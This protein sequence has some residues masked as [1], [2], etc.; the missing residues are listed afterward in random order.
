MHWPTVAEIDLAAIVHNFVSLRELTPAGTVVIAVVKADAY[1]HGA[2]P[3]SRAL[4]EHGA[5]Y[6]AVA[7]VGEAV[8]LD[9][10]GVNGRVLVMGAPVSGDAEEIVARQFECV[11]SSLDQ[12]EH[13]HATARQRH[14]QIGIHV[15]FDTGMGRVGFAAADHLEVMHALQKM[16]TLRIEGVMTHLPSSDEEEGVEFTRAQLAR[17][18]AIKAELEAAGFEAPLWH[19]ANTAGVVGFPEA[20]CNAIRPGIGLYGCYPSQDMP[21]PLALRQAMTWK[22]A[23]ARLR[24]MPADATVSYGRTWRA[25]RPSRIALLSVG[26][27][28]GYDRRLSNRGEVLVRGRRAPVVG[29]V[30]MDMTM[31]DVTDIPDA[32]EGDEVVLLGAQGEDAI[33]IGEMAGVLNTIPHVV[34]TGIGKR[35]PR[36]Y[37]G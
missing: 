19:A 33:S 23:I 27:A 1:G 16:K 10:A 11:V 12:A 26:Y 29:R 35:V 14:V 20:H 13:L 32:S 2:V 6:F 9:E 4:A 3:V 37:Y 17:F 5:R 30:C 25:E 8:E 21:Q 31:V 15:M 7:C 22:T 28:D 18:R 34:I 24:N 36:T